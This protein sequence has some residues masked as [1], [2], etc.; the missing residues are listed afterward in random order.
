MRLLSL[1]LFIALPSTCLV[2][3]FVNLFMTL[4]GE[5]EIEHAGQPVWK[6]G[7]LWNEKY[8]MDAM[9]FLDMVDIWYPCPTC[10]TLF[11][12]DMSK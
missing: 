7:C 11:C 6:D 3:S 2:A 8:D 9:E 12:H 10:E 4:L 5:W 1:F